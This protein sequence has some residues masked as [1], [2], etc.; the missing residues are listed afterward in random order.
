MPDRT[1][2]NRERGI[3]LI[4]LLVVVTI[5]AMFGA[6]VLPRMWNRVG[7]AKRT[8]ARE[9][10]N[11]FIGALGMYKLDTGRFPT[12]E[13]GLQALRVRPQGV[14]RWDGPYLPQDIPKDPWGNTYGYKYPGEHGEEPDIWS[15]GADNQQGGSGEA[16]DVLSWQH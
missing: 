8:A 7:A 15:L 5:I 9:Q 12:T 4:E 11:G 1:K 10:I 13:Q 14:D 2:R 6:L 16:A 3:T